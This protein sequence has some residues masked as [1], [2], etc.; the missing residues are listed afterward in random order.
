MEPGRLPRGRFGRVQGRLGSDIVHGMSLGVRN[1]QV[2]RKAL[3][4]R[5]GAE[6]SHCEADGLNTIDMCQGL[7]T[8]RV[9]DSL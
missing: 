5:I 3:C 9:G 7:A 6:K 2:H 1:L 8:F 4:L